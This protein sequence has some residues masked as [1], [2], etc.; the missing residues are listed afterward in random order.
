VSSR[1]RPNRR[2]TVYRS[3]PDVNSEIN[4]E[5]KKYSHIIQYYNKFKFFPV[6]NE[7][8]RS[9]RQQILDDLEYDQK[10]ELIYNRLVELVDGL[11]SRRSKAI[12]INSVDWV[13]LSL[14]YARLHGQSNLNN[15]YK[16]IQRTVLAKDLYTDGSIN[17]WGWQP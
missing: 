6:N 14:D 3:V 16:I 7:I 2:V 4:D 1:G 5:I 12:R 10:E 13:T 9:L 11:E 17:E 15:N 8:V